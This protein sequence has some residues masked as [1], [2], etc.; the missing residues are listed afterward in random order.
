LQRRRFAPPRGDQKGAW[1][2]TETPVHVSQLALLDPEDGTPTKIKW[3]KDHE[4]G[5]LLR[6]SKKSGKVIERPEWVNEAMPDRSKYDEQEWDTS[7][8]VLAEVT[9]TPTALSFEEEVIA[10]VDGKEA[11]R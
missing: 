1:F 10:A 4:S 3:K 2:E 8:D 9:Y 6:I 11:T 5:E 7:A